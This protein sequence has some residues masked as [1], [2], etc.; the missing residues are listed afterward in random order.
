MEHI[1]IYEARSRFSKLVERVEAGD[2]VI[3]TRRGQPVARMIR[4]GDKT[5]A[6]ARAAA[7]KRIRALRKRM[8]LKISRAEVKQAIAKGRD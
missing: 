8:N 3:L 1:G 6:G 2:E 7:V 4:V 5:R